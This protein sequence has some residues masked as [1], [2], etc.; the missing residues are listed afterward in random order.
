MNINEEELR[1]KIIELSFLQHHKKYVHGH[2]GPDTFDCAGLVWYIYNNILNLDLYD[3]GIGKSTTTKMM[4]SHYGKLTLFNDNSLDK[5]LMLLSKGD[6][7]F[8]HRQAKQENEPT[9]NN[10]YPGHCGIYLGDNNFI[11]CTISKGMVIISNFEKCL[12]WKKI[13]V[14]SKEIICDEKCKKLI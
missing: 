1:N 14:A 13:L 10:K 5:N 2:H 7:C 11:H 8:F 12:S 3:Q 4:T 9:K 6:I